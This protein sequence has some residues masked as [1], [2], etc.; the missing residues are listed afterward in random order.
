MIEEGRD[1][2]DETKSFP[3]VLSLFSVYLLTYLLAD[4]TGIIRRLVD[5]NEY[6][7]NNSSLISE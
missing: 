1:L 4:L 2:I 7:L 6:Q 3:C 5:L